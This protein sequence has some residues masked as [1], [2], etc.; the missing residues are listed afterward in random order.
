M[1]EM[2]SKHYIKKILSF[3]TVI[4]CLAGSLMPY[5]V[6]A[7]N[8][9]NTDTNPRIVFTNEPKKEA[10]LNVFKFVESADGSKVPAE[11]GEKCNLSSL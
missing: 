5:T 10:N 8:A 4:C 7:G 6:Q 9:E 11:G 2:K 3:L 1:K